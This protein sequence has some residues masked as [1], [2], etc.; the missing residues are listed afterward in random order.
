MSQRAAFVG[1]GISRAAVVVTMRGPC[2]VGRAG[3]VAVGG[4]TCE[5]VP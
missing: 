1:D 3:G 4:L 5:A 2:A